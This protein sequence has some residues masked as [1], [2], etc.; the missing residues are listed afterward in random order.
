MSK[1]AFQKKRIGETEIRVTMHAP[2]HALGVW[3]RLAHAMLPALQD[4]VS[5]DMDIMVLVAKMAAH[6]RPD[7]VQELVREVFRGSTSVVVN[8]QLMPLDSDDEINAAFLGR[9][10]DMIRAAVFAVQVNF[11]G[12]TNASG[13]AEPAAAPEAASR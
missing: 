10:A 2:M 1:T 5:P 6:L 12:F 3:A 7:E 13:N 11:Q 8:G 4:G 9:T